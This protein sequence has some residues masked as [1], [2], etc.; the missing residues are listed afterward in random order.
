MLVFDANVLFQA[1][2]DRSGLPSHSPDDTLNHAAG[3]NLCKP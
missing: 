3:D 1:S 2:L